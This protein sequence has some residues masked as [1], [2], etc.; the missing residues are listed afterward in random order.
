M[1]I[2]ALRE[3]NNY[4]Q[5]RLAEVLGVTQGAVAMWE[6]GKAV[7]HPKKLKKIAELFGCSI[8]DL[9]ETEQTA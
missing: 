3:Q 2:K 1:K 8:E 5:I 7:P 9:F 6:T 4:T